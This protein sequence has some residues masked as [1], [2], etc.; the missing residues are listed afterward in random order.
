MAEPIRA[1]G[2]LENFAS[3]RGSGAAFIKVNILV[4]NID[5]TRAKRPQ[6]KRH[7]R[8]FLSAIVEENFAHFTEAR[9]GGITHESVAESIKL[10]LGRHTRYFLLVGV[11]GSASRSGITNM[12][13]KIERSWS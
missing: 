2:I 7:K 9:T 10:N 13:K 3:K 1:R 5:L 8:N 6:C 11:N 12:R 4:G